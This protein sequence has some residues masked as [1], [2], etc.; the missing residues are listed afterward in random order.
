VKLVCGNK[1][2]FFEQITQS[3]GF[4]KCS[5]RKKNVFVYFWP[6]FSSLV[7]IG[8]M[9]FQARIESTW[10]LSHPWTMQRFH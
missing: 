3:F 1:E 8:L 4:T 9:C 6:Q 7:A 5:Y 2:Y 10:V